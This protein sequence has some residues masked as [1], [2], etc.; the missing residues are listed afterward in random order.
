MLVH[1]RVRKTENQ[2]QMG[3]LCPE[4][5]KWWSIQDSKTAPS[6]SGCWQAGSTIQE[7]KNVSDLCQPLDAPWDIGMKWITSEFRRETPHPPKRNKLI[8]EVLVHQS[9]CSI[10]HPS[11]LPVPPGGKTVLWNQANCSL[12]DIPTRPLSDS[13]ELL[14]L[15]NASCCRCFGPFCETSETY[16]KV[17]GVSENGTLKVPMFARLSK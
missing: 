5:P 4:T 16:W 8:R 6:R 2:A 12:E 1:Q 13:L 14:Q 17:A 11:F 10:D 15:A 9:V 7:D 3:L